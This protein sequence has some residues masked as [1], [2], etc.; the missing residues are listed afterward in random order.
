VVSNALVGTPSQR[1]EHARVVGLIASGRATSRIAISRALGIA[2]STASLR[3]QG[4]IDAGL[5]VESGDGRSTGGRRAK[6][7]SLA[8][9]GGCVL[10]VDL[11]THHARMALVDMVGEIRAVEEIP[12]EIATGPEAVLTTVVGAALAIDGRPRLRGLGLA[13]PG[14]VNIATGAVTLPS[15][16]P[17]WK[18]FAARDWLTETYDIPVVVENDANL[19]AYGEYIAHGAGPQDI[20]TVKAGSG[21][22][23]GI[24]VQGSIHRGATFAAGDIAHVRVD[25]AGDRPCSCGN[26]GCLETVASGAA[27]LAMLR[28]QGVNV[29]TAADV[30]GLAQQG[31]PIATTAVRG[32]GA[33]LGSVL[34]AVTNFFNPTAIY[35]GGLLST[36]ELFVAAVRSEIYR[37]SHPLATQRLT[38]ER[39]LN[40]RNATL[41][42]ASRLAIEHTLQ[43]GMTA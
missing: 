26:H 16:M 8:P 7:L 11:G 42:G 30:V 14:P 2:P 15:R 36:V 38:I 24:I 41:I 20:V 33:R 22:G 35:L 32:A 25:A 3:V 19:M 39:T 37:G 40:D 27:L 34:C 10:A 13:L 31:D 17:G 9:D 18:D 12:V 28:T 43:V 21:I 29:D 23:A 4:L 6:T 5:L 1:G